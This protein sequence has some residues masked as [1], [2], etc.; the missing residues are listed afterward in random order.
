MGIKDLFGKR[1]N[2]VVTKAQVERLYDEV[3]S[4]SFVE[5]SANTDKKLVTRIDYS[6]PEN[7]A[8]YGSAEKYYEDSFG[9]IYD[10]YPYDGSSAEKLEW[11]KHAA[12]ID[13]YI[14]D[15]EYP[16]VVGHVLLNNY[17]ELHSSHDDVG[18][19]TFHRYNSPQWIKIKG[20]P[21]K[22][23]SVEEGDTYELSN[24]LLYTSP[25]PRDRG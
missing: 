11:R 25:S 24:C 13:E 23:P 4:P 6:K 5:H 15:V 1:S 10:S 19:G 22:D 8:R 21:N 18:A 9:Y 17:A 20:G 12:G 7:F 16:K 3:E 2:K 14:Y